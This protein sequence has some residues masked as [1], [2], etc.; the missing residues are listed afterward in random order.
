VTKWTFG[1]AAV[2]AGAVF[3]AMAAN[4]DR[5]GGATFG[6]NFDT[7]TE[8]TRLNGPVDGLQFRADGPVRCTSID[9]TTADGTHSVFSGMLAD[10]ERRFIDLNGKDRN[11]H[12]ITLN[13]KAIEQPAASIDIAADFGTVR[14]ERTG[15]FPGI[16]D[17]DYWVQLGHEDFSG[18]ATPER[19]FTDLVGRNVQAIGFEAVGAD[20]RCMHAVAHYD[21]GDVRD[22]NIGDQALMHEGTLYRIDLPGERDVRE[23]DLVCHAVGDEAVTINLYGNKDIS[24]PG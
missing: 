17:H 20:A 23:V 15:E 2:L 10:R 12:S 22:L 14:A 1:L 8:L 9:V 21:N 5:I 7:H 6:D 4:W 24:A 16:T 11:L 18:S 3:P 19:H 13:C